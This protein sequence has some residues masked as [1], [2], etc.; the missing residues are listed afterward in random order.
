MVET[1]CKVEVLLELLLL[2]SLLASLALFFLLLLLDRIFYCLPNFF[3]FFILNRKSIIIPHAFSACC[4]GYD[5][6][7]LSKLVCLECIMLF[8]CRIPAECGFSLLI[9]ILSLELFIGNLELEV[10]QV[11]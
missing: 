2:F 5:C 10:I 11:N 6:N 9:F 8:L 1:S 7:L 4:L 3:L